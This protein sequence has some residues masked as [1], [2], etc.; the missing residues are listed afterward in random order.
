[1]SIDAPAG[2]PTAENTIPEQLARFSG[3]AHVGPGADHCEDVSEDPKQPRND[4][5]NPLHFHAYCRLPNQFQHDKLREKA[6]AAKGRRTRQLKDPETDAYDALEGAIDQLAADGDESRPFL[7]EELLAPT[8]WQRFLEATG[9]VQAIEGDPDPDAE[10]GDE[11]PKLYA[12]VVD[13]QRRLQ[14]L[15]AMEPEERPQDELEELRR[16]L[17]KYATA[18]AERERELEQP[19]RAALEALDL[20]ALLDRVRQNRIRIES[21][22]EFRSTYDRWEWATCT[23][24]HPDGP[25]RFASVEEVERIPQEVYVALKALYDDLEQLSNEVVS[26]NS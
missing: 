16:H 5:A 19:V 9:D 10:D 4:C 3:W 7:I 24:R 8:R 14:E 22:Q 20:N 12:G 18:V 25:R 15:E 13:D 6:L 21:S 26:G 11:P 1:M 17:D 23:L 2:A